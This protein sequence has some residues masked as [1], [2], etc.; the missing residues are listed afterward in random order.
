[1]Q[2]PLYRCYKTVAT[3]DG[4]PLGQFVGYVTYSD[5]VKITGL[6]PQGQPIYVN[7]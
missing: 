2:I 6:E 5:F 1:M 7:V 3:P 4:Y